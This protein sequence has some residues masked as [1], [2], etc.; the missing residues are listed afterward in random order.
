LKSRCPQI[1][2]DCSN[3]DANCITREDLMKGKFPLT[4]GMVPFNTNSAAA[5]G[6]SRMLLIVSIIAS[7]AAVMGLKDRTL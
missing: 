7:I 3:Y 6:P 4:P 5:T 1:E 2:V